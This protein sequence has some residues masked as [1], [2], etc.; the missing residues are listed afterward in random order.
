MKT[1]VFGKTVEEK[2]GLAQGSLLSPGL[3]N[4]YLNDLLLELEKE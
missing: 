3:F 2:N 1:E 4:L